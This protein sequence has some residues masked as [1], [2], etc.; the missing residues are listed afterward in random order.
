MSSGQLC[1]MNILVP[2]ER[3][4]EEDEEEGGQH[5]QG[6]KDRRGGGS[7]MEMMAQGKGLC[8]DMTSGC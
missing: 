3:E 6:G 5:R 4:E 2:E 7:R 8:T 1:L